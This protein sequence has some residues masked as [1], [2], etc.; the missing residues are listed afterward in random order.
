MFDLPEIDTQNLKP[1]PIVVYT[2]T[3]ESLLDCMVW[4]P[5]HGSLFSV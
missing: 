4:L 2:L 5:P 1:E 3:F